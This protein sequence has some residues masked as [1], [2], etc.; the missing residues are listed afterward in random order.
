M[1]PV[2]AGEI[3]AQDTGGDGT[4]VVL[5]NA[6]WSTA[7]IWSPLI[8]LLGLLGGR[9]RVIRY[10]DRGYGRSPAP[11]VPFTRLADLRAVLDHTAV[12]AAVVVG[13]SG[14]GGTSLGLALSEPQRVASLILIAPGAPDYPWPQDDPYLGEFVR[15][16]TAGDREGLVSLGLKTWAAAGD[17]A[18]A[19]AE[20]SAAVSGFFTV[21]E[22]EQQGPPAYQRLGEVRAP[23]VVIR[24]DREYPMVADSSDRIASRIPGCRHLVIAGADHLLP[25]RAPDRLAEIITGLTCL[26]DGL[27]KLCGKLPQSRPIVASSLTWGWNAWAHRRADRSG[28][29]QLRRNRLGAGVLRPGADRGP[30]A[31]PDG[32]GLGSRH[33]AL[34]HG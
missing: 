14:G 12:T 22:L 15:L 26:A 8:G 34:R 30:S 19:A 13:H 32:R 33:H 7:E 1:I 20:I 6:N 10:D 18:P 16:F 3:W 21:G 28:L 11:S 29:R 27:A 23:A 31:A 17:D 5:V 25:L 2:P 24:G 4:P 9:F